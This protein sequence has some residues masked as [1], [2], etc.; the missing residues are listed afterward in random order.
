[1][2]GTAGTASL[3]RV[4]RATLLD[5]LKRQYVIVARAKG[6]KESKVIF[7]YPVRLALNPI[8]TMIGIQLPQIIS[9]T[10]IT[11]VVLNLPTLGP[12]LLS[13]L[14]NQDMYLAGAVIMLSSVLVL[15]SVLASDIVL[16]WNDPRIR[17]R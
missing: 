10:A 13:S 2:I 4:F 7:K 1:M 6:L 17:L 3:I 16:A 5:E 14:L 15:V 9:G 8:I 12:M 11:A